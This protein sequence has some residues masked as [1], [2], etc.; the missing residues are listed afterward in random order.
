MICIDYMLLLLLLLLLQL[1]LR[2][3]RVESQQIV[4]NLLVCVLFV[5][6]RDAIEPPKGIEEAT[7]V[8]RGHHHRLEQL[9]TL[10]KDEFFGQPLTDAMQRL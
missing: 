3:L 9:S 7:V 6:R 5:L 10:R 4:R 1:R 8:V 2:L